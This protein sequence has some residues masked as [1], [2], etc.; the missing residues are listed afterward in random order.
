MSLQKGL[1]EQIGGS[2]K[3]RS[4]KGT[5]ILIK[6]THAEIGKNVLHDAFI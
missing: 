5:E 1:A 3:L 2:Y 6:F 4:E